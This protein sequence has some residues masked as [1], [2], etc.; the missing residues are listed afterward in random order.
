[1]YVY[2]W[3]VKKKSLYPK[4]LIVKSQLMFI[5]FYIKFHGSNSTTHRCNFYHVKSS[6]PKIFIANLICI[7]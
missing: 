1:M 7:S 3:D 2:S 5:T 4:Y 6:R